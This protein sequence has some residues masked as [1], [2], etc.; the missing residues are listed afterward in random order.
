VSLLCGFFCT[1]FD[2]IGLCLG[3]GVLLVFCGTGNKALGD[4]VA[5]G[6]AA[7]VLGSPKNHDAVC[8]NGLLI[9]TCGP[10]PWLSSV[11]LAAGSSGK[12]WQGVLALSW[13]FFH[14]KELG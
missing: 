2:I 13:H 12:F 7:G 10:R 6:D 9:S 14:P 11:R 4:F 8:S 5:D 3:T 1:F